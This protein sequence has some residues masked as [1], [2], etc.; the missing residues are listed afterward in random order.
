MQL[1]LYISKADDLNSEQVVK[2]KKKDFCT[3]LKSKSLARR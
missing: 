2:K 1:C 3:S